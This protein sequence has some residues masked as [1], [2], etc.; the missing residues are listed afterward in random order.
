MVPQPTKRGRA[1]SGLERDSHAI[2]MLTAS[3]SQLRMDKSTRVVRSMSSE[4]NE[5]VR[6]W[7][8]LGT[9]TIASDHV[10]LRPSNFPTHWERGG[11]SVASRPY[12]NQSF[13]IMTD[14]VTLPVVP[15]PL[16]SDWKQNPSPGNSISCESPLYP[17]SVPRLT[18][19]YIYYSICRA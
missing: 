19:L 1:E 8:E 11:K 12:G 3:N 2:F 16:P 18:A 6:I 4:V 17:A 5:T 7:Q 14:I 9:F 15:L 10:T 13:F